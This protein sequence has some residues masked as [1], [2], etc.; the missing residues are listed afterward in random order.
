MKS[1]VDYETEHSYTLDVHSAFEDGVNATA[2]VRINI[3][4]ENDNCPSFSKSSLKVS[5]TAPVHMGTIVA[6]PVATDV[7][8]VGVLVYSIGSSHQWFNMSSSGDLVVN[9]QTLEV[10]EED[11]S[12][13]MTAKVM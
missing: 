6:R 8:T 9:N 12:R 2:T 7:D 1:R 10:E 3:Q 4:D 11:T 13:T 5:H